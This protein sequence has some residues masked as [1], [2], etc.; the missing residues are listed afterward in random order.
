MFELLKSL[1]LPVKGGSRQLHVGILI[2]LDHF[3]SERVARCK[4]DRAED[5]P[6]LPTADKNA[7]YSFGFTNQ[8]FAGRVYSGVV[9][10]V[11]F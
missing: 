10:C 7:R 2:K 6:E 11:Q 5:F 1:D 9:P 4:I 3:H 8:V